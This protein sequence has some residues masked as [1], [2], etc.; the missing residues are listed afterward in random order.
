MRSQDKVVRLALLVDD[1]VYDELHQHA[2][3]SITVGRDIRSDLLTLDRIPARRE[4]TALAPVWII[5]AALMMLGG[6]MV[7][8]SELQ[9]YRAWSDALELKAA[10][11]PLGATFEPYPASPVPLLALAVAMLSLVPAIVGISS[12]LRMRSAG[13]QDAGDAA[14]E[15]T[16]AQ[17]SGG[18]V[19]A[20]PGLHRLFDWSNG[21]YTLALPPEARGKISLGKKSVT[22]SALRK[23]FGQSAIRVKL[24]S[25]AKGKIL[26]GDTTLLF[27]LTA[28]AAAPVREIIPAE[29]AAAFR[30]REV[31]GLI[32]ATVA[33]AFVVIGGFT[34]Y[35]GFVVEPSKG[36]GSSQRMMEAMG[37]VQMEP[38]EEKE[39]EK[40]PEEEEKEEEKELEK[41]PDEVVVVDKKVKDADPD[42]II[43]APPTQFSNAASTKAKQF[44]AAAAMQQIAGPGESLLAMVTKSEANMGDAYFNGGGAL[45]VNMLGDDGDGFYTAGGGGIEGVGGLTGTTGLN[46]GGSG[47]ALADREKKEKLV[48]AKV[49]GK[50]N[51]IFGDIDKKAVSATIRQ[52][53]GAL[54]SCYQKVLQSRPGLEGKMS[55]TITI[56]TMGT[57]TNVEVEDDGLGDATV[58]TCVVGKIKGWRFPTEGADESSDVSFTA[59]FSGG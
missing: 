51:D 33:G 13:S 27:Q 38:K 46:T 35:I 9:A 11:S 17:E 4:S 57:V 26:L 47:P 56:S 22:I 32:L 12:L 53:M 36:G 28:P 21:A 29:L 15:P 3:G 34:G 30:S 54:Q 14:P 8:V 7:F 31:D 6:G 23:Q 24:P 1:V 19:H 10:S 16:L 2:P 39:E 20:A 18:K 55:F 59:V 48:P 49:S 52:R 58:R 5:L 45:G 25:N 43:K 44:G 37:V 40:K 50:T 41:D 42:R